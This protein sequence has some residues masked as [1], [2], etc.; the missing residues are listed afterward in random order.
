MASTP[1]WVCT[2]T[3]SYLCR[4]CSAIIAKPEH[5]GPEAHLA[6]SAPAAF[7]KPRCAGRAVRFP[8]RM[9]AAVLAC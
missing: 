3:G 5:L 9:G 8:L 6:A 7:F 1:Q 4:Q 2:V